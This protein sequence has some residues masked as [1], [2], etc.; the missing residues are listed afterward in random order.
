[1]TVGREMNQ[2]IRQD[3]TAQC[4]LSDAHNLTFVMGTPVDDSAA[5][6]T[7]F[8]K[9]ST[10]V[11]VLHYSSA[12]TITKQIGAKSLVNQDRYLPVLT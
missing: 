8:A 1:M 7:N 12:Y 9:Q 11:V 3:R 6:L 10:Q 2:V 4:Q 5:L